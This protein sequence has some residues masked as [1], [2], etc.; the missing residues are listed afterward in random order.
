[1]QWPILNGEELEPATVNYL[2]ITNC[3]LSKY[4]S[5]EFEILNM[6]T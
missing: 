1:M 3:Y 6:F 5:I 2:I 4:K